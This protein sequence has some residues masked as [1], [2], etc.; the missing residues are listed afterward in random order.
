MRTH[1]YGA[2]RLNSSVNGNPRYKIFTTDGPFITSSDT[3]ASYEVD[4]A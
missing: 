4:N 3:S 1:L 2:N